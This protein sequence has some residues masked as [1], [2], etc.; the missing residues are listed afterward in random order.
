MDEH[1]DLIERIAGEMEEIAITMC[2]K[3]C[4]YGEAVDKEAEIGHT[5][6]E[7]PIFLETCCKCPMQQFY[8]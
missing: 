8:R 4:K 1:R 7:R 5:H 3:F 6:E 2:D